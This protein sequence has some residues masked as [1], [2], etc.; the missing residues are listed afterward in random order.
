MWRKK[1]WFKNIKQKVSHAW[2][3][4]GYLNWAK[5]SWWKAFQ[6]AINNQI[7]PGAFLKLWIDFLSKGCCCRALLRNVY[8]LPKFCAQR[9]VDEGCVPDIICMAQITCKMINNTL[10]IH[11]WRLDF[12]GFKILP[13]F[14]THENW[15]Q[16]GANLKAKIV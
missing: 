7:Y 4:S 8:E 16:S 15:L 5:D 10:L 12:F 6:T 3:P 11:S 9:C 13:Q 1:K 14:L 2:S